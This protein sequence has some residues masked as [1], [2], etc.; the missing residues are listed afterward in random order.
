MQ[1]ATPQLPSNMQSMVVPPQ[2]QQPWQQP[3]AVATAVATPMPVQQNTTVMVT[4]PPGLK[5]GDA[6]QVAGTDGQMVQVQVPQGIQ[7]GGQFMVQM[8]A[9]PIVMA[10]AEPLVMGSVV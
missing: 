8:P 6:L 10:T 7:P 9:A 1:N 4:C 2:I 3:T 5:P